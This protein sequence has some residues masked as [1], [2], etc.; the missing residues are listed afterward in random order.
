MC[1]VLHTNSLLIIL[2]Y[3]FLSICIVQTVCVCTKWTSCLLQILKLKKLNTFLKKCIFFT[4]YLKLGGRET[5]K[6]YFRGRDG[7]KIK[8]HSTRVST[9]AP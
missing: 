2:L 9:I 1:L 3:P 6:N 4:T 8:N 5:K 7:E